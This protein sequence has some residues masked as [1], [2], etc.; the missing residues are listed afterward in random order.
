VEHLSKKHL[1]FLSLV[2]L[3]CAEFPVL[4]PANT[5]HGRAEL[6]GD[7]EAVEHDDAVRQHLAYALL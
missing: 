4:C 5:I 7:V 6:T 3:L 1:P 2:S